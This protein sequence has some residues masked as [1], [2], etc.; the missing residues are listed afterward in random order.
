M[1]P[2]TKV[3]TTIEWEIFRLVTRQALNTRRR[4]GTHTYDIQGVEIRNEQKGLGSISHRSGPA[5]RLEISLA[6]VNNRGEMQRCHH[7]PRTYVCT[8][9]DFSSLPEHL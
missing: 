2:C 9:V 8:F 5:T 6:L 1:R 4:F 3:P 7:N